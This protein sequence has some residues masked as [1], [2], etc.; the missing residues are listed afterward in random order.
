MTPQDL[1]GTFVFDLD[2]DRFLRISDAVSQWALGGPA[3]DGRLLWDTPVNGRRGATQWLGTLLGLE[4]GSGAVRPATSQVL[5]PRLNRLSRS[6]RR[7]VA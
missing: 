2:T 1:G 5:R 4:P 6:S 7:R 3:P